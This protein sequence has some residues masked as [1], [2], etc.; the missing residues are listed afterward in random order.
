MRGEF[1]RQVYF[2]TSEPIHYYRFT[3]QTP[4]KKEIHYQIHGPQIQ[5][6]ITE[7]NYTRTYTFEVRDVPALREEAFMPPVE[8]LAY[9]ISISSLDS[10]ETLIEWYATLI[11]EQDHITPEIESKTKA[12]LMG[13]W[14][15]K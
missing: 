8:D 2:Q 4:K 1:W 6:A 7:T 14:T 3:V 5:P 13:A 9:S 10:W 11:R 12:L 15:R